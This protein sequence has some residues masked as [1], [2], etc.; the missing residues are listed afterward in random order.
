MTKHKC[1]F[2]PTNTIRKIRVRFDKEDTKEWHR[3]HKEGFDLVP[4]E[5][6]YKTNITRKW[7]CECGETKWVLEK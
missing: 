1:Q 3:L 4:L 2:Y 5:E 7:V 6:C